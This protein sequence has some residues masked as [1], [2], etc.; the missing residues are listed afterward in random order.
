MFILITYDVN[1]TSQN[2]AKRLRNVG[3]IGVCCYSTEV[4]RNAKYHVNI[5]F[6]RY[7]L[8]SNYKQRLGRFSFKIGAC[9]YTP[10]K[11]AQ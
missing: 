7:W 10:L 9:C 6:Y 8:S 3:K 2:G 4:E 1:I 11:T 5:T